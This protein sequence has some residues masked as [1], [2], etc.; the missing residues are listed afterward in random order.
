MKRTPR[1]DEGS[2]SAQTAKNELTAIEWF[3]RF[4]V[5]DVSTLPPEELAEWAAWSVNPSRL[6]EFRNVGQLWRSLSV[7]LAN[8]DPRPTDLAIAVDG[9]DGSIPIS[10]WRARGSRGQQRWATS[11]MARVLT[12]AACGLVATAA[13]VKFG[14][15]HYL[16]DS[17]GDHDQVR[18]YATGPSEHRVV[19]LSDGSRITLGART[20]LSTNFTRSR[21]MIF[22]ERGE[23]WF[24]AAHDPRRPFTVLAGGGAITAIG[25]QFDV[26]RELDSTEV[27]RVT[28]IVSN[29]TVEVGPPTQT[30][31][32]DSIGANEPATKTDSTGVNG[33]NRTD[34]TP[35]RL[36]PGQELTYG[37]DGPHGKIENVNLEE[38]SAWKEGRLEYRHTPLR[39][40]IPRVN[41]YSQKRIVLADGAVGDLPFSGTVFEGQVSEWLRALQTAFPIE[42]IDHPEHIEIR[43]RPSS[44]LHPSPS[45]S[46][47]DSN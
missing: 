18:S 28:V 34:W 35:A 17:I 11:P 3:H 46:S 12:I 45:S 10:E 31:S 20:E 8:N 5:N 25:T 37:T 23:A 27:D 30:I 33:H 6:E 2:A 42:V 15:L 43:G 24:A 38:A 1:T 41:R 9:Y 39:V 36:V 14:L 26:R 13:I 32:K 22:L 44:S 47:I 40:V 21:R 16:S 19:D 29:G 4:R 7:P